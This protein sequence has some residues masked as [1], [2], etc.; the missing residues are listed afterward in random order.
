M[1][2]TI[3]ETGNANSANSAKSGRN[4][5]RPTNP[6]FT[7]PQSGAMQ[8][9]GQVFD[10]MAKNSK[11]VVAGTIV[12]LALAAVG[13]YMMSQKES[14]SEAGKN[15]LYQ[16]ELSV[17][18]GMAAVVKAT[19]PAKP[20]KAAD[21][22]AEAST[23]DEADASAA[24]ATPEAKAAAKDDPK[25]KAAAA[26]RA[27]EKAD[28]EEAQ[29]I[30]KMAFKK[31]DVDRDLAEGVKKLQTVAT[32]YEGTRTGYEARLILGNLY[33]NHGEP[34][35]AG[36][37]FQKAADAAPDN[38]EKS[39]A[40]SSLGYSLENQNKNQ[41]A[42]SAFEKAANLGEPSV[43]ADAM[44]GNA[45]NTQALHDNAKARTL[46]DQVI[47]QFPNSEYSKTAE[48]KKADL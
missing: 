23:D 9:V 39:L 6:G 15:A 41:E 17:K 7:L 2:T 47:S 22:P 46:Y 24:G 36:P 8:G 27:K 33:F 12:I 20:A 19:S 29:A 16:A 13:S 37:W 28:Q 43:K 48:R 4:T 26:A 18:S 14:R 3:T 40:L 45:R 44:L 10:V 38:L 11:A 32:E 21:A 25:A 31:L 5:E 34:A 42:A 35:K 30:E 1:P